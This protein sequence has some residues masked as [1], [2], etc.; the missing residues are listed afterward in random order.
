MILIR[1][2]LDDDVDA[3]ARIYAHYVQHTT[4]TFEID[5]P[6]PEEMAQRRRDVLAKGLPWLV[7][8]VEGQVQGYAYANW[9]KPRAAYRY[10]VENSIYLAPEATGRRLGRPLLVELLGRCERAGLRRVIAVIGD[11]ANTASIGLHRALGFT[12][13]GTVHACGW[14]FGRWIDIVLMERSLGH[15]AH[16]PPAERAS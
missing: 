14:K 7:L 13:A 12:H 10:C 5:P 15:G 11:T 8:E 9:F 2:S 6:P 4:A 3:I 16:T 1:P